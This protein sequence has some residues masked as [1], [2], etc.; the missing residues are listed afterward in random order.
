MM[1][2]KGTGISHVGARDDPTI[3]I[4]KCFDELRLS[5]SLRL[6]RSLNLA[7]F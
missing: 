3:Q 6:L 5:R 4:S 2:Q 1:S 7:S